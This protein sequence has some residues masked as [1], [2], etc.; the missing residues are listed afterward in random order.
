MMLREPLVLFWNLAFPILLFLV[1]QIS[2]TSNGQLSPSQQLLQACP[3]IA[4]TLMMNGIY[5]V[6]MVLLEWRDSGLLRTFAQTAGSQRVLLAGVLAGM[7]L[8][9]LAFTAAFEIAL[10]LMIRGFDPK[11]FIFWLLLAVPITLFFGFASI[12]LPLTGFRYKTLQTLISFSAWLM[13]YLSSQALRVEASPFLASLKRV[14]P[15]EISSGILRSALAPAGLSAREG[16]FYLGVL[17]LLAVVAT[18]GL[19]ITPRE[20]R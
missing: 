2:E 6:G 17:L 9:N 20:R 15:L 19:K 11:V 14:S 8:T 13:L 18:R 7:I 4:F 12:F 3:F 1:G 16:F 10:R 5:G